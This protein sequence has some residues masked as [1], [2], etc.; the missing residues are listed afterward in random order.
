MIETQRLLLREYTTD[1]F[2]ALFEIMSDPETMQHY[3]APFD[4][5]RTR[6]WIEWNLENY[7]KYGFGLWAVVLKE[8]GEFIG[9]CGITI[10][11]I[12]G[13]NLPEIGYH[14]HKKYWRRG[15][16]KEAAQAVRD[17][18]FANTDYPSLYSY[19]K[20]TNEASYKT[21]EA[22]GMHFE[23]EYNDE[24]NEITHV[25]VIH[26]PATGIAKELSEMTLEE[27]WE[28]FPVFLVQHDDRW[29][30]YYKEIESAITELLAAYPVERI[31]HIGSTAIQGIW[32][33]NIVDVMVE[34]SEMAD[35][36]VIA[37]ILEQ[38]G[39][40]KMS[41]EK[42]RISLN[43]GYTK[44]GF[45]DKVYHIH[46]RYSGDNDE[47]Y[48]RDYL[49]EHPQVAGDYEALKLELWKKY[50]HDRDAYTEAKT[51]FIRKWTTKALRIY[52]DRY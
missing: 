29:N 21:A 45:A 1:D 7:V 33:K 27:L 48:F 47:L 24:V 51:D 9:D 38:N 25:S 49:N 30:I 12:D 41:D 37:D 8:T 15:F 3:P 36:E 50:E 31:S 26:R 34:I 39:F 11:K 4:E 28:L 43:K 19:C 20:Y 22:I 5:A 42:R 13:E 32:A 18:A 35:M 17:W 10:Q 2:D 23:K 16:A 6:R 44:E 46:I 40:I 52:G 14:I